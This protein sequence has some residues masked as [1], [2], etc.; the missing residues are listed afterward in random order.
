[1]AVLKAL[2]MLGNCYEQVHN[3]YM[4][5]L[6]L[7]LCGFMD[8]RCKAFNLTLVQVFIKIEVK[9]PTR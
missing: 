8:S 3:R 5:L 6:L 7:D 4:C 2:S 1:M 9:G